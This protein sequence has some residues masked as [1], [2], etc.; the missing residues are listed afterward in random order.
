[1]P[2]AV[3]TPTGA[4]RGGA[5]TAIAAQ[6]ERAASSARKSGNRASET[7]TAGSRFVAERSSGQGSVATV[8]ASVV[9]RFAWRLWRVQGAV[10]D[11]VLLLL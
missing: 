10:F 4:E 11:G 5:R 3:R 2:P 9:C 8:S 7:L 6:P 1:M